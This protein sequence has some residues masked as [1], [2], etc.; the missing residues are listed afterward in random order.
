LKKL[1]LS[2]NDFDQDALDH[3]RAGFEE[4]GSLSIELVL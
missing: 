2:K 4:Q 1:D 3:L